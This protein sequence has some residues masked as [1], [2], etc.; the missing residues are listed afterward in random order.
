[1]R[2]GLQAGAALV[3]QERWDAEALGHLAERYGVTVSLGPAAFLIDLLASAPETMAGLRRMKLFTQSGD[4]L[5]RPVAERALAAFPFRVSRALGMT[6]FGHVTS[7][8]ANSPREQ[9][10]DSA[11]SPQPEIELCIVDE[12]KRPVA[13]G[14]EGRI[15]V[16]GPFVC[17]G[18]LM[19]DGSIR[20]V[21]DADGFFDTGDLG[22]LDA[23]GYLHV[24]G[25]LKNIIRRG[26]ITV[27]VADLE[28]VLAAHPAVAHAV[29]IG[30]P[31]PRLGEVPVACVQFRSGR[32]LTMD[33]VRDLFAGQ[34][35]TKEFWPAA[36]VVVDEWPRGATDKIDQRRLLEMAEQ[37]LANAG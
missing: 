28:N 9:V 4:P 7:T 37:V 6:E 14:A 5:P 24:T 33:D 1:M 36:L 20:D 2:C 17:A 31:D 25:R 13:A 15:L 30:R 29:I 11:G 34:G 3:L 16:R 26:A 21:T 18:Y 32:S 22:R 35:I 19:A 10:I 8:D 27:P 12:T 23:E